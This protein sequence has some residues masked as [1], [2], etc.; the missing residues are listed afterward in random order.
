MPECDFLSFFICFISE[1]HQSLG[2]L[3]TL[4]TTATEPRLSIRGKVMYT[5]YISAEQL[6]ELVYPEPSPTK[7]MW[8]LALSL[9]AS[10]SFVHTDVAQLGRIPWRAA[11]KPNPAAPR[12]S[13][14]VTLKYVEYL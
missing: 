5:G 12:Q 9:A 6:S 2:N 1:M 3:G 11:N 7:T 13:F 4:P 10:S 8:D 14:D